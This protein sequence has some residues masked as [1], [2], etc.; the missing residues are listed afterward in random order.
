MISIELENRELIEKGLVAL[1]GK[2]RKNKKK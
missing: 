1:G 2:L